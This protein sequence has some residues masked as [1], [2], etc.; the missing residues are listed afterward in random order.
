ML[1]FLKD[2]ELASQLQAMNDHDFYNAIVAHSLANV[3]AKLG[4]HVE[5]YNEDS[6]G[7]YT[8]NLYIP[9]KLNS[10]VA[11]AIGRD[12]A[13]ETNALLVN[14]SYIPAMANHQLMELVFENWKDEPGE[15]QVALS[16]LK[17]SC[18]LSKGAEFVITDAF[19]DNYRWST[20]RLESIKN[21]EAPS[22]SIEKIMGVEEQIARNHSEKTRFI[23]MSADYLQAFGQ[24]RQFIESGSTSVQR[25]LIQINSHLKDHTRIEFD[26]QEGNSY[27]ILFN[28]EHALIIRNESGEIYANHEIIP[29]NGKRSFTIDKTN[30]EAS[31][32]GIKTLEM[33]RF[34]DR[35]FTI[36]GNA[37][38]LNLH[39]SSTEPPEQKRKNSFKP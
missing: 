20:K 25:T 12:I 23:A 9:N 33:E 37:D 1:A 24:L 19:K 15:T 2:K 17:N 6:E 7:V 22:E 39:E 5:R 13:S 30:Y 28:R 10:F 31:L 38:Y 27:E 8:F 34:D 35:S 21:H 26:G 29:L 3:Y 14:D 36:Q 4:K 16:V 18:L 11:K 32:E